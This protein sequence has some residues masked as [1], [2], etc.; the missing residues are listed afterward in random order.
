MDGRD[1]GPREPDGGA[2]A[3]EHRLARGRD[4]IRRGDRAAARP[5]PTEPPQATATALLEVAGERVAKGV[6]VSDREHTVRR[7]QPCRVDASCGTQRGRR[8]LHR[9]RAAAREHQDQP[10]GDKSRHS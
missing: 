10:G 3:I 5:P 7:P 9:R 8:W 6:A 4:R 2:D 1:I